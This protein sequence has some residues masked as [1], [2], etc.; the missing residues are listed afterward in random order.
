MNKDQTK[1]LSHFSPVFPVNDVVE[2]IKWYE[3]KL[4]FHTDFTWEEP[5]TYAV[6]SR[7]G[8]KVHFTKKDDDFEPSNVHTALYIFVFDVD[9]LFEEIKDKGLDVEAPITYEY[10]MRDFDVLDLNGFRLTFGQSVH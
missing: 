4:G 3:A 8:I 5:A 2:T 7:D 6:I 10:G 1:L 9:K